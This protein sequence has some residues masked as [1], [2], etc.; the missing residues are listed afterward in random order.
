[1]K[2]NPLV[3]SKLCAIAAG[4][5][6]GLSAAHAVLKSDLTQTETAKIPSSGESDRA[7][8]AF[9]SEVG[10]LDTQSLRKLFTQQFADKG[11]APSFDQLRAFAKSKGFHLPHPTCLLEDGDH[12]KLPCHARNGGVVPE[13]EF[14]DGLPKVRADYPELE[15]YP[16]YAGFAAYELIA[17]HEN[18]LYLR[19]IQ[20]GGGSG[21]F[22]S[23]VVV[24]VEMNNPDAA[25]GMTHLST[26]HS[27]D[28]CNGGTKAFE[29]NPDGSARLTTHLT[30][31]DLLNISLAHDPGAVRWGAL[32]RRM[33]KASG[34][35]SKPAGGWEPYD[36][37]AACAICCA[38]VAHYDL[39][40][41]KTDPIQLSVRYHSE[42]FGGKYRSLNN[43]PIDRCVHRAFGALGEGDI[44][45]EFSR[46]RDLTSQV[47]SRCE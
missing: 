34:E 44:N 47:V 41:N 18:D 14:K 4:M 35:K 40:A 1:M 15:E 5:V 13:V 21:V 20:N 16:G 31:F 45:F 2:P 39:P 10:Y 22:T 30:T 25:G 8:S 37:I 33:G 12:D 32:A 11:D 36:D 7:D 24:R 6:I 46:W 3:R 28:R 23:A 27:G 9:I 26:L 38:G 29:M 19:T 42:Y 43:S 17:V